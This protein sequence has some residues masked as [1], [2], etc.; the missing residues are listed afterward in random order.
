MVGLLDGLSMS[1]S[2]GVIG[3]AGMR[4]PRPEPGLSGN[5]GT[6]GQWEVGRRKVKRNDGSDLGVAAVLGRPGQWAS[7]GRR[8][9]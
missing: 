1:G 8:G 7:A 3:W 9:P 4:G 5:G 6:F 2:L